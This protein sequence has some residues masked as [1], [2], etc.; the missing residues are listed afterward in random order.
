[1]AVPREIRQRIEKG[2]L[3]AVESAWLEHATEAPQDLEWFTGIGRHL[4]ATSHADTARTL[5]EMLADELRS[6]GLARERLELL[7]E[8]GEVMVSKSRLHEAV[9]EALREVWGAHPSFEPGLDSFQLRRSARDPAEIWDRVS[10]LES[11]L[12]FAP[13][14]IVWIEGHGAGRVGDVNLELESFRMELESGREIRVGFRA[15]GKLLTSLEADHFVVQ[16]MEDP[17]KLRELRPPELL[18]RILTSFARPVT[19]AELRT[20]VEG[21][22]PAERWTSWWTAARRHSQVMASPTVRNAYMWAG[23]NEEATAA[24]WRQ[25]ES[26]PAA[27]QI[28]LLRKADAQ[29]GELRRRMIETLKGRA[30]AAL[31]NEAGLAFE[32]ALALDRSELDPDLAPAAQIA[33][34]TNPERFL[35]SIPSKVVR[36]RAYDLVREKRPDWPQVFAGSATIETEPSLLAALFEALGAHDRTMVDRLVDRAL[37]QPA[38]AP[39]LFTW[40]AERAAVDEALRSSA[41]LRWF[42]R[43]LQALVRDELQPYRRRL[44]A[45]SESGGTLPRLLPHFAESD[46]LDAL[47]SLRKSTGLSTDRKRSL[48]DAVVLRFPALRATEEPLYALEDSIRVKREEL[49]TL[50]E[51]DIPRNRR[52]IEEARALG[53]LRENFEY[54]SARQRHEYLSARAEALAV[55]LSRSK[56]I[57][58]AQL[59]LSRIGIGTAAL[60]RDEAGGERQLTLL[61]PW[62]SAPESGVLSYLSEVAQSLL[63]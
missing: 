4:A 17:A 18:E 26:A 37:V 13:G 60:L 2:D 63:G 43:I 7:R 21:L 61:G 56:A 38:D 28:E 14:T 15:A 11:V 27:T 3:D 36:G 33:A 5:L 29:D 40:I 47:E 41:P 8:A 32:I 1:M 51:Q 53:D 9:I 54:K 50:L 45:L 23:S 42:K 6:R 55:E 20:A 31:A 19:V 12:R 35:S 16:K 25:F 22:V 57:D 44:V 24:L 58:L 52:A 10:R 62:E 49:K 46:A 34:V 48:E 59:D 30:R 39:A